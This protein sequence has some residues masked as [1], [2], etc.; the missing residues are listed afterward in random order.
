MAYQPLCEANRSNDYGSMFEKHTGERIRI[1]IAGGGTGGH[2]FP[3]IAIA[4]GLR[5]RCDDMDI[6][7]VV[8]RKKME[9]AIIHKAGFEARSID[10]E[11]VLGKGV[12]ELM[13]ALIKVLVSLIQSL[14]IVRDFRPHLIV[15]VGGYS[16]GP[17]CLVAR[18]LR[19]PTAI[20]E[21]NSFPGLTNRMLAPLVKKVFISFEESRKYFKRKDVFLT[22]NPVREELLHDRALSKPTN[23]TFTILVVGGSQGARAINRAVVSA[24][25]VL[26]EQGLQPFVI[27]QTGKAHV[28]EIRAEYQRHGFAGE[29]REFIDDMASA[30]GRADL[31]VCRA[32][33]TTLAELAALGKP[34][35]LIPYPY[36]AHQHQEV[37][38]RALV[39]AGG[40]DMILEHELDGAGLAGRIKTYMENRDTLKRMSTSALKAGMPRAKEIIAD[41]LFKLVKD[42]CRQA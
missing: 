22:G 31:V 16:S 39:A 3:G 33:A 17:L 21:Q 12:L 6:L 15:G 37:N 29:V 32:G 14:V 28:N 40:A 38:A 9:K 35:I 36:A 23:G 34:S 19:V 24:L 41:E 42:N 2:L 7:F 30:Y 1:I 4:T 18:L 20:H 5:A 8:G 25:A 10:V 26:T 11:G 27:H 13:R